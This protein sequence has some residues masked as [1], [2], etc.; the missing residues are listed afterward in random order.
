MTCTYPQESIGTTLVHNVSAGEYRRVY[1]RNRPAGLEVCEFTKGPLTEEMYDAPTH[2]HSMQ[3]QGDALAGYV[4]SFF[5]KNDLFLADLMDEFDKLNIPYGYLNTMEG[6]YVT[7]RPH[8]K[9]SS[10]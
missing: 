9:K 6:E 2:L 3:L 1:V 10:A 7:Y 5:L 8:G 4:K